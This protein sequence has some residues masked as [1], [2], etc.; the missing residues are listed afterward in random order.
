MRR[1]EV[2]DSAVNSIQPWIGVDYKL[3]DDILLTGFLLYTASGKNSSADTG[4][5]LRLSRN[6]SF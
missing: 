5:L 6:L 2:K 3:T 4:I 1:T